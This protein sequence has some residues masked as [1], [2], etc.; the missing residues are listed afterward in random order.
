MTAVPF[1]IQDV[2]STLPGSDVDGMDD[3]ELLKAAEE[4]M[5]LVKHSLLAG[6]FGMTPMQEI[7]CA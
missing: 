5:V 7:Y 2:R 1:L 3:N 4:L 6:A